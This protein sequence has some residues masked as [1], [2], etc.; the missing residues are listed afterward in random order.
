MLSSN[1]TSL[2]VISTSCGITLLGW[3]LASSKIFLHCSQHCDLCPR[4]LITML[5][6]CSCWV[7]FIVSIRCTILEASQQTCFY[8]ILMH[9]PQPGRPGYMFLSGSSPLTCVAWDSLTVA[10]VL[11]ALFSGS[12]TTQA[13]PLHQS[14]DTFREL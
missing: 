4:F 6:P 8:D 10:T 12:L 2:G 13:P 1:T 3:I 9:N 14:R 5:N 7:V 11:P